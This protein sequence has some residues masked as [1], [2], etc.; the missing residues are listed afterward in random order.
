MLDHFRIIRQLGA[1]GMGEVY[2]ARDTKLGRKVAIKVIR[3]R[4]LEDEETLERFLFEAKA[5]AR[6]NHPHIV[7]IY[8]VDEYEGCPYLAL[9]YLEGQNLRQRMKEGP[10]GVKESLRIALAV[11]SA[12]QEAHARNILHRDLKP[13]NI[14][15]PRDGR[16]RVLDFG[17]AKVL[18]DQELLSAETFAGGLVAELE[19]TGILEPFVTDNNAFKGSPGYMA[20]EQ[21]DGFDVT[22]TT[23]IWALGVI[24][25][26]MV[27]GAPPF[28]GASIKEMALNT[29]GRAPVPPRELC[30]EMPPELSKLILDCLEKAARDRP[31]AAEVSSQIEPLLSGDRKKGVPEDESPFPGLLPFTERSAGAFFGRSAE[32]SA[33]VERLR[34]EPVLPVVGP[35]G[36][37]KSSFVMAGV[38]PRLREQGE[39]RVIKMRP[40]AEPFLAL[41]AAL[42]G[43]GTDSIWESS[44]SFWRTEAGLD[45]TLADSGSGKDASARGRHEARAFL[46]EQLGNAPG[47][48]ALFLQH[49]ADE[50]Q[51]RVLLFVDQLE[52]VYSLAQQEETRRR[53]TD[54]ICAA[55]DD[56]TSPVRVIFTLRDDFLG[57]MA[58][59][60][61]ARNALSR[62]TVLR[63][64][65][66][67]ALEE[68]LTEPVKA[69]GYS[70]ED[71]FMVQ[72]MIAEVQGE[73][74]CLPMLQVATR[75]L[76]EERNT[77]EKL[78][79]RATY[80]AMGASLER[81]RDT[82]IRCSRG[83]P[84]RRYARRGTFCCGW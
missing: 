61:I 3:R 43:Q 63:S 2:L 27:T 18:H 74:A 44:L 42:V 77:I 14:F 9:E 76:W 62:V 53:F 84:R 46:A 66:K 4:F 12:L 28:T 36:A 54:A 8:A 10:L 45:D 37:G 57:R 33:F 56:P 29:C 1:G 50:E 68:I 22:K 51:A 48:L 72:E 55:A 70:Y 5:T 83:S 82:Q 35:S 59:G 21:W 41:A 64:P 7:T 69:A 47:K 65:E 30:P 20:P 67:Q 23:D 15:I 38:V 34:E 71:P 75:M 26:E 52:E 73:A 80:E 39:W 78:L 19:D 79:M 32:V 25:Y 58:E 16:L 24:L 81:S 17:I 11:T 60:P 13:E 49:L 6:F 40:G 31:Q